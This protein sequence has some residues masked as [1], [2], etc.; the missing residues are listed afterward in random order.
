MTQQRPWGVYPGASVVPFC[1]LVD[2]H[3][4]PTWCHLQTYWGCTQSRLLIK[5]FSRSG[6]GTDPWGTPLVTSR[7]LDLTPLTTTLCVSWL[8]VNWSMM[9]LKIIHSLTFLGTTVRLMGLSLPGSSFRLF[10]KMGVTFASFQSTGT[11]PVRQ[12]CWRMM[13]SGLETTSTNSL[14]ALG[15]NSSVPMD[16]WVSSFQ[17][18]SET[19][20]SQRNGSSSARALPF[21]S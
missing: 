20:S 19:I 10:L 11:S 8:T 17:S 7:Q 6:P 9:A 12:D 21:V 14:S 5:I 16:L 1:P 18:S 2:Q 15:C 4:L 13:E 3:S